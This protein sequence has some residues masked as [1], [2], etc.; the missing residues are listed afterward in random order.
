MK[1]TRQ[2][3]A[4]LCLA[5]AVACAWLAPLDA[6]ATAQVDAGLK[7]ALVSFA[8]A[9]ALHG[10]GGGADLGLGLLQAATRS[11]L[12]F[13]SAGGIAHGPLCHSGGGYRHG[14]DLAKVSGG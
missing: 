6:P 10:D 12:A 3:A 7:R 5:L 13:K 9:R 8:T 14:C 2:I 1:F 4:A 11:A